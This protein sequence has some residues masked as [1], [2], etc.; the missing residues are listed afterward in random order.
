MT[1]DAIAAALKH[2]A[3]PLETV[4]AILDEAV[5]LASAVL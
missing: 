5:E 3:A 2:T 1:E 4:C